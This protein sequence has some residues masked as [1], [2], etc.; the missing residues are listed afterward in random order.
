MFDFRVNPARRA[1]AGGPC[2]HQPG[3]QCRRPTIG[4]A[5]VTAVALQL[6]MGLAVIAT[7]ATAVGLVACGAMA[8]CTWLYA[9]AEVI[10]YYRVGLPNPEPARVG[11]ARGV[12]A[13]HRHH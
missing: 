12:G 5:L 3:C 1:R 13:H 8:M 7:G 4:R 9:V 6:V 10:S 11:Q 2:H